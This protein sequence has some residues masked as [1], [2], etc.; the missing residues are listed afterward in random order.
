MM[1]LV[2]IR[3]DLLFMSSLLSQAFLSNSAVYLLVKQELL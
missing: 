1:L 3:L 2:H